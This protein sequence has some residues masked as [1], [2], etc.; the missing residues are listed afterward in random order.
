MDM[1]DL[2]DLANRI[3]GEVE[4]DFL[5]RIIY[6]TDA[7][8][9][10]EMPMGVV[11]PR[12]EEDVVEVVRYAKERHLNLIPR[13]GGTSL[14]GQVVGS[15]VVVDI[16]RHMK[17]ILEIN[18]EERWV[19]VQPGVV[20]DELN[21]CCKPY[22]LFFG[23]E[24]STSNRC[25]MGGM[26]GNNSCGSH[27]L[28]YGSTRDHLLEAKVVLSDGSEIVLKGLG[29][30]EVKAKMGQD[31]LEGKIYRHIIELLSDPER[32]KE[33]VENFPEAGLRRRNSGYAVDE[34]LRTH[35]FDAQYPQL[36]NLCRLLAGS[37]GTLA[38]ITELKLNLVP[39]PPPEKAVICVHCNTLEEAFEANLVALKHQPVAVELMDRTIL[40]LSKQNIEQ[41]KNRFFIQGDPGAILIVELAGD[42]KETI[43]QLADEIEEDLRGQGYGFHYPRVYGKDISR[44]WNLRK[45]GL[46]LLSGMPGSAKPV[47]V[48]ED[49][50]VV[51][52]RLPAYMADFK[53]MLETYGL[54]CVYHAHIS[55]GEL[56]LRPVLNLKEEKDRKLFRTVAVETAKL[57]KK[58]KG[59]LSGE[60]GDGRLRGEFIPFLFGEKVYG[61][62]REI[63]EVWDGE[64]LF[65]MGK[66][67]NT[68]PMDVA[69]RCEESGADVRT[70]FNFSRQKGWLCAIEQ[71]NGAG[72]CRKSDLFGG[73]MCPVFRATG[74]ERNTTRAR[75][76]VLRELMIHPRGKNRFDQAEI[77]EILDTCVSCKACKS[78]CPSNVD[79]ARFKAEYL[80]HH[81]DTKH[82]PLRSYLMANLTK[83][84]KWGMMM[85]AVYNVFVSNRIFASL[86]KRMLRFAPERS[87][88]R[89]Y[90]M[91]LKKWLEKHPGDVQTTKKV[92]LF[93]DEFTNY[94]DVEIGICFVEM[95]R[96]LGYTVL[97]PEHVESGRT[98]ISKGL[99]KK[100]KEI[101]RKNVSLL[102]NVVSEKIPLVGIEPSC[103]LSFRD[104]YPDLVEPEE[105]EEA[106][107]LSKNCLLYDEFIVREIR[108]GNIC[109]GQFTEERL[110][111]F[112]H[113]HCHQK[114]LASIE[115]SR[116][117]L[118][119]PEN[120]EVEVIPSGC[121]GMAGS[122]GYEKEHY[123]LSLKIGEQILFPV[124]RKAA[125]EICIAAP[126]TSCRQQIKDGTGK[127]AYH[128]VEILCKA[129]NGS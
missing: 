42:R 32:Q 55:T 89:L 4:T 122:F 85:P 11:Y 17:R 79:M 35:Y 13:A 115:P 99:L 20:L 94:L 127:M 100:A 102:K 110:K 16:S 7:S 25:C 103:I 49:T 80:Q 75:A 30:E 59:S 81:Y 5:Y 73:T 1:N 51:P 88:P 34:L 19:R 22:G 69:L 84:E 28:V 78:E 9:Y 86:L 8:A 90:K 2:K 83:V 39:L 111:I 54:S 63:K 77:L 116:E 70:Y 121:C 97:I 107:G 128:P 74:E 57:V 52:Q 76:N 124:V 48:I 65:N 6:A 62:L 36:F 114:S 68:P 96:T 101:A 18:A 3:K 46:G 123:E 37:E 58:H 112:L 108:K 91:G 129:L 41:N 71:C 98:E 95:L 109:S 45:A 93:A 12:D 33:I 120:Y 60:H 10:R 43:D 61:Y 24:T 21:L 64:H 50:A 87:I 119:L 106:E 113:G 126:G 27:S 47:S 66:I 26:V 105:Q 82:I 117:M 31:D 44:V 56:H 15:G 92:Y 67:V 29:E 118:S 104:E 38:F 53:K 40:E 72:D 23:P 14:A 125:K